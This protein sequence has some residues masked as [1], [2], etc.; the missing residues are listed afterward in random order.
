MKIISNIVEAELKDFVHSSLKQPD[1]L[2][3]KTSEVLLYEISAL[4][5]NI[6]HKLLQLV[7]A[8]C[9]WIIGN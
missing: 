4:V 6:F 7:E 3:L 8:Q 1:K 2:S 9:E 5:A